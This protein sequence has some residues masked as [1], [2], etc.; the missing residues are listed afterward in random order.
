ML[1][2]VYL[3]VDVQLEEVGI[4]VGGEVGE[5][6]RTVGAVHFHFHVAAGSRIGIAVGQGDP[7]VVTVAL[8]FQ[9]P[10]ALASRG[11]VLE[12]HFCH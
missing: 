2:H 6:Q 10:S 12:F 1:R 3:A 5:A 4:L 9:F 7:R 8:G 11:S